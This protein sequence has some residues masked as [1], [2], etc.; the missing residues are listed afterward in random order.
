M[1]AT[2]MQLHGPDGAIIELDRTKVIPDDPGADTPAVLY[3][4][5]Y[6]GTFWCCLNTGEIEAGDAQLPREVC[7]W[8]IEVE[9]EVNDFLYGEPV[10]D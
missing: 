8:L 1:K 2:S 6:S 9:D 7:K 10:E 4:N 5:G 3:W